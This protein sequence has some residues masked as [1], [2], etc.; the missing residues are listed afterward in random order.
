VRRYIIYTVHDKTI[1]NLNHNIWINIQEDI[2]IYI[3]LKDYIKKYMS[4]EINTYITDVMIDQCSYW[5]VS[6]FYDIMIL[7]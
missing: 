4:S 2:Y 3:K 5:E 7:M 1:K 6:A